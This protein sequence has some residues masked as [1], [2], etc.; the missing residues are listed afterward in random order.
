MIANNDVGVQ[1]EC[2]KLDMVVMHR[3]SNELTRLREDNL[4]QLLFDQIPDLH[5]THQSHDAFSQYLRRHG[6]HVL[7]VKDLLLQTLI[8]S[9]QAC[10]TL[11]QGIISNSLFCNNSTHE[12]MLALEQWLLNRKPEQ[13]VE[14]VISGVAYSQHELG[15]STHAQTL[16]KLNT[17]N[18]EF[19]I[20]PLPNLLF[21]RDAFSVIEKNV[22][23]WKM[24][25][26]ARQNEPLIFHVIFHYH[27]Q[28]SI[29]GLQIVQWQTT[30]NDEDA[31]IEGGDVAY[32]G[33]GVLLIGCGERTN[34]AGIEAL[35]RTDLF[36]QVIAVVLPPQRDYMH[37]DTVLSSVGRHAFTLHTRLA[38][39]M[40]VFTVETRDM[41]YNLY[42]KVQWVSHGCDV[43]QGLEEVLND[44]D[45]KFYDGEDE[46]TSIVEQREC[47]HNVLAIDDC[48]VVTYGGGDAK[49]G[50]VAMM[51]RENECKVGIIP[52]EGLLEGC[53]GAHCMTNA[54]GRRVK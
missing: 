2:G 9:T 47:R 10:H 4:D 48:Y 42:D 16:L 49:K 3:S 24:A 38:K 7:Y 20:P 35:A 21:T 34:R 18:N 8:T 14:D 1:S 50:L 25:K 17:F 37:L 23:I 22:F 5:Q 52:T 39:M 26:P 15:T 33:D 43:R 46:E 29:S 45:L 54:I 13:L 19:I 44:D 32:L 30:K 11:I 6:V 12:F 53:G 27:P 36:R 41:N 51:T 40:E 28:L 31:T